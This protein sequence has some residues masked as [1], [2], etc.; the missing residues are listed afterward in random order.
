MTGSTTPI[1]P[2]APAPAPAAPAPAAPAVPA[3]NTP[4]PAT[5][6]APAPVPTTGVGATAPAPA[7]APVAAPPASD[8]D[9]RLAQANAELAKLNAYLRQNAQYLQ[10]GQQAAAAKFGQQPPP[11]ANAAPAQPSNPFG[12]PAFDHNLKQFIGIDPDTR[13]EVELRGAPLGTLAAYKQHQAALM[14]AIPK[15]FAD[16]M[17]FI[18]PLV[19]KLAEEKAAKA[20]EKQWSEYRNEQRSNAI[21]QEIESWAIQ[22][23]AAGQ[24]VQEFDPNTGGYAPAFTPLGTLYSQM[25]NYAFRNFGIRDAQ[26]LHE[27]AMTQVEL[28]KAKMPPTN[29]APAAAP[30]APMPVGQQFALPGQPAFPQAP[31]RVAPPG[32]VTVPSAVAGAPSHVPTRMLFRQGAAAIGFIP[33]AAQ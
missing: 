15:F 8:A 7:T 29:P 18:G 24:I 19:E 12:V 25:A 9:A 26:A 1:V 10:L 13:E 21:Y 23:D 16:P 6:P 27:Y 31:N 20:T 2:S 28:A 14:A 33:T 11:A 3:A 22:R 4:V 30:A 32:S 17:A 5:P